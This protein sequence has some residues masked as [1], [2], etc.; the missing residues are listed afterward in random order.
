MK[1]RERGREKG[2][3]RKESKAVF[4][5][6]FF[7]PCFQGKFQLGHFKRKLLSLVEIFRRKLL[8]RS[9]AGFSS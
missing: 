8:E 9:K 1:A 5:P 6:P 7:S 2:A 3:E 4:L